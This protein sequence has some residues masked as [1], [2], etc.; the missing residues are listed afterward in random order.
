MGVQTLNSNT[1]HVLV[2]QSAPGC[3][4][5]ECRNSNTSHVLV[6]R[7]QHRYFHKEEAI[8]IHPMFL[9]IR[10]EMERAKTAERFK[11]IPCYCLS[12]TAPLWFY[13][14]RIQ[15]HPM[16]L[17]ITLL[18][19]YWRY[20]GAIQIH[21]MF[22]F[23]STLRSTKPT[24]GAIQIHPM[25]LFIYSTHNRRGL[26]P[27]YSNTSHVLVYPYGIDGVSQFFRFKYIPCSCLSLTRWPF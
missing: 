1:S 21:P 25:F 23:I 14:H 13:S 18:C 9:F 11:Y 24:P 22:L 4:V 16:F 15:I 17:F 2:Y 27:I 19:L 7:R 8:Q 12:E 26:L 3:R 6:Y 10:P 5:A 20:A